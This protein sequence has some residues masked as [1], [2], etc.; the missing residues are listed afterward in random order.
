MRAPTMP[1]GKVFHATE[2]CDS[3]KAGKPSSRPGRT[4]GTN[5]SR[6][7]MAVLT[8]RVSPVA[9]D[10]VWQAVSLVLNYITASTSFLRKC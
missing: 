4:L 6:V 8:Q 1:G 2:P 5:L 3:S 7:H 9:D 10:V